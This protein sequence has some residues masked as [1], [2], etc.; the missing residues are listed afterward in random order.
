MLLRLA[1][2]AK[3]EEELFARLR[4]GDFENRLPFHRFAS[5]GPYAVSSALRYGGAVFRWACNSSLSRQQW[6]TAPVKR[7]LRA[8]APTAK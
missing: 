8:P 1:T 3:S 6:L 5:R 7:L 2:L 4:G